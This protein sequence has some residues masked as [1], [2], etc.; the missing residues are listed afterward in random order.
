MDVASYLGKAAQQESTTLDY[1]G[2]NS[3]GAAKHAAHISEGEEGSS[4]YFDGVGDYLNVSSF[5]DL[6]NYAGAVTIE[7]WFK[8]SS[9]PTGTALNNS[10]YLF[11]GGPN[12][13]N[14]GLDFAIGNT[15]I[16]F[17][18][19]D[20][21]S[22]TLSGS[23]TPDTNWHHIAV[24]RSGD[25][26]SMYLDGVS[27]ASATSATA[28]HS[29]V[30]AFAIGRAEQTGGEGGGTYFH[31][32]IAEYRITKGIARYT[33]TFNVPTTPFPNQLPATYDPFAANTVLAMHMDGTNGSTTFYD[34]CGKTVTA[35]GNAQINT[36]QSKFGGSSAYFDGTGDYLSLGASVPTDLQI[37]GGGFTI[38][39][40]LAA[41]PCVLSKST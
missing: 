10:Y 1:W 22:R 15:S 29:G 38:E 13:S 26:W 11:G 23:W 28:I 5:S 4:I 30:Q 12:L 19:S 18:Q 16:W 6:S 32:Y 20:Y 17:S 31:G 35:N 34:Q 9:T 41:P 37:G 27:I 24:V 36:A 39:F 21:S 7:C 3:A 25:V 33:T 2:Y 14:A 8:L 40:W